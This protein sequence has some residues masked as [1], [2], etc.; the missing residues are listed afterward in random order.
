[1][2]DL[3]EVRYLNQLDKLDREILNF[4]WNFCSEDVYFV[5]KVLKCMVEIGRFPQSVRLPTIMKA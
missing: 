1:M 2:G 4:L 5:I 3:G